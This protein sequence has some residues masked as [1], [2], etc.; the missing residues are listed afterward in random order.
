MYL[1]NVLYLY[2]PN[3]LIYLFLSTI[4]YFKDIARFYETFTELTSFVHKKICVIW[5]FHFALLCFRNISKIFGIRTRYQFQHILKDLKRSW[6]CLGGP[7]RPFHAST[8]LSLSLSLILSLHLNMLVSV[9]GGEL[10]CVCVCVV[11]VCVRER[12]SESMRVC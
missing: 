7:N 3:Y 12:K 1:I 11:F 10:Y 4:K 6:I 2:L 9:C 8:Y 5:T